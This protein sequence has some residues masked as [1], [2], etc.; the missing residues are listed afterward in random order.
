MGKWRFSDWGRTM[1]IAGGYWLI[2]GGVMDMFYPGDLAYAV[3]SYC[4]VIGILVFFFMWPLRLGPIWGGPI[5]FIVH[6]GNYAPVGVLLMLAAPFAAVEL[7]TMVGAFVLFCGGLLFVLGGI[8]REKPCPGFTR[9]E[10]MWSC[11]K[12]CK[13]C[14]GDDDEP[15]S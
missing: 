4:I 5:L 11:C 9:K 13:C 10:L 8:M 6:W 12:C 3:G 15:A 1:T 2:N 7:P 14:G